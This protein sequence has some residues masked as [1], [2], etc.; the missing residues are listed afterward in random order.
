MVVALL[1]RDALF[2]VEFRF[3]EVE[4]LCVLIVPEN[5]GLQVDPE[6][7]VLLFHC[8]EVGEVRFD[9]LG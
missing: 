3:G 4:L 8:F 6:R 5:G 9:S 7:F 1:D 2:V